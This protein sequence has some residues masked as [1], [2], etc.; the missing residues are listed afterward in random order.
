M[1]SL[2]GEL[3]LDLHWR[4]QNRGSQTRWLSLFLQKSN[5]WSKFSES[6]CS[7]QLY[8]GWHQMTLNLLSMTLKREKFF[9][10]DSGFNSDFGTKNL[11]SGSS[12][13]K[14]PHPHLTFYIW[15][16]AAIKLH[17][18][19]NSSHWKFSMNLLWQSVSDCSWLFMTFHDF[20]WFFMISKIS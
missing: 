19:R 8:S 6:H 5:S 11:K 18:K 12:R 2:V 1:F 17:L 20:P 13:L 9:E 7:I 4:N 14:V 10:Q 3:G 15:K 16:L